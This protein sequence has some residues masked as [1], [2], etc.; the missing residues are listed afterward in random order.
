MILAFAALA[1]GVALG[2]AS[3]GTL[4]SLARLRLR[5]EWPMLVL[6]L[7]QGIA[8]GRIIGAPLSWAVFVWTLS[9]AGLVAILALNYRVPG[10]L[11]AA[12]G[13]L[14][15]LDPPQ[16]GYARVCNAARG[17][18]PRSDSNVRGSLL[19]P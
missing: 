10:T 7:V 14:L 19:D 18:G 11:V 12:L 17:W 15:N 5:L 1:L 4:Q 16:F 9:S 3:G 6:F 13:V 8:R 2:L